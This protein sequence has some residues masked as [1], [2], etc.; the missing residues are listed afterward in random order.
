MKKRI[1]FS[2]SLSNLKGLY[3]FYKVRL[4]YSSLTTLTES[5]SFIRTRSYW[6]RLI[7]PTFLENSASYASHFCTHKLSFKT[8]FFFD[9]SYDLSPS[10][11]FD[12][13]LKQNLSL[14]VLVP[15]LFYLLIHPSIHPSIYLFIYL[16]FLL[17]IYN[18]QSVYKTEI[19]STSMIQHG[20]CVLFYVCSLLEQLC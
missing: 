4:C 2:R 12:L 11:A 14:D 10:P 8:V 6:Q 9:K 18:I 7:L 3:R 15:S 1:A 13:E 17:F 16:L 19:N 20:S 5:F